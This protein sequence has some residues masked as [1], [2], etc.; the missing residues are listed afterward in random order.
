MSSHSYECSDFKDIAR[1][2][3]KLHMHI[4]SEVEGLKAKQAETEKKVDVLGNQI[5]FINGGAA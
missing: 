2:F 3:E 4:D 5:E 1:C